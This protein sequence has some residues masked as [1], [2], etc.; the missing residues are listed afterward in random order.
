[1]GYDEIDMDR[2]HYLTSYGGN[3]PAEISVWLWPASW[4]ADE[5]MRCG[6]PVQP[7]QENEDEMKDRRNPRSWM[8]PL[9]RPTEMLCPRR[10]YWKTRS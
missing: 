8:M 9:Q 3:Q 10:L 7:E 5:R 6:G 2:R 1:M 4:G